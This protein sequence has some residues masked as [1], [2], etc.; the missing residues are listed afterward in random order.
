MITPKKLSN[1]QLI[2]QG[3]KTIEELGYTLEDV[4]IDTSY[5]AIAE[6]HIKE[7]P[8]FRFGLWKCATKEEAIKSIQEYG[9]TGN[10]TMGIPSN[11]ELVFFTQYEKDLDKFK[12]SRSGFVVGMWRY[13]YRHENEK[14][15]R[16]NKVEEWE[17]YE[18]EH[19]LD[20][21]KN[22]RMKAK[23]YAY[24]ER[25]FIWEQFSDLEAL[26]RYLNV[27]YSREKYELKKKI[28][29][30]MLKI[31]VFVFLKSIKTYNYIME[32]KGDS[33]SPRYKL[34]FIAKPNIISTKLHIKENKKIY[35][36]EDELFL[37]VDVGE[38]GY[39]SII[40]KDVTENEI[41]ELQS[42]GSWLL[43]KYLPG[44]EGDKDRKI[45][46]STLTKEEVE[47][48]ERSSIKK[49]NS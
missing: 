23:V 16:L 43:Y 17:T 44:I 36:L 24:A 13:A 39:D 31:K 8:G 33:W 4:E 20:F 29:N 42:V 21:I 45:I 19:A 9:Y 35:D 41:L 15:R 14:T 5:S 46:I 18:L 27:T 3:L 25:K 32:D 30:L 7:I 22:H 10:D 11:S 1:K 12:P 34:S 37:N 26:K 6:F 47:K 38:F 28:R 2:S 40:D 48:Y 49:E